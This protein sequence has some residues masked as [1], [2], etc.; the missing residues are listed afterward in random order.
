[1]ILLA[2]V[3]ISVAISDASAFAASYSATV[4][5]RSVFHRF[6]HFCRYAIDRMYPAIL[7]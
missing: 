7:G 2:R 4:D 6:E 5:S 1:V 3:S